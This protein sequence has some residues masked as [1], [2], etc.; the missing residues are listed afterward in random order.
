MI[1]IILL[2]YSTVTLLHRHLHHVKRYLITGWS[3]RSVSAKRDLLAHD[4]I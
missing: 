2:Y 1:H 3:N 4:D